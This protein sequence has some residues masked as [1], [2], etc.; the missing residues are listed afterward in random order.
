MPGMPFS[1][2]FGEVVLKEGSCT[3]WF[4]RFVRRVRCAVG[5]L[6]WSG[7]SFNLLMVG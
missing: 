7:E 3:C 5:L 2:V 1:F 6:V 4:S